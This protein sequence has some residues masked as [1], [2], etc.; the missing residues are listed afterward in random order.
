M[1]VKNAVFLAIILFSLCL[2]SCNDSGNTGNVDGDNDFSGSEDTTD[3]IVMKGGS[4]DGGNAKEVYINFNF[5]TTANSKI[6]WKEVMLNIN[7]IGL[8]E[9]SD[10]ENQS[11]ILSSDA[12]P[13]SVSVMDAINSHLLLLVPVNRDFCS[14]NFALPSNNI[15]F[16]AK[17]VTSDNTEIIIETDLG[18]FITIEPAT[19]FFKFSENKDYKWVASFDLDSFIGDGYFAKLQTGSDGKIVVSSTSNYF[20]YNHV[21]EN[22]KLSLV[23]IE[24]QNGNGERDNDAD[25][26]EPIV[27]RGEIQIVADGDQD[28][29]EDHISDGDYEFDIE[30]DTQELSEDI[31]DDSETESPENDS[32]EEDVFID[33]DNDG[34]DDTIDNCLGVKNTDQLD[35]DEDDV[36]D[37]CDNCIYTYNPNQEDHDDNDVGDACD[38]SPP[39]ELCRMIECFSIFDYCATMDMECIGSSG[40]TRGFCSSS[41]QNA[42]DC[43][44]PYSCIEGSC[45]CQDWT[46]PPAC[47]RVACS[48]PLDCLENNEVCNLLDG[49]C[50]RTCEN[51]AYCQSMY[52]ERWSC[53]FVIALASDAC[54]CN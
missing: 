51:D 19:G 1:Q 36:G 28:T 33:D 26:H 32:A 41:C 27:G 12:G 10:C 54:V 48:N 29:D 37:L 2:F 25:F 50:T 38:I 43:I 31:E 24:D 7:S 40:L 9:F 22:I 45:R 11:V 46:P 44:L 23:I 17:G 34:V 16:Q 47:E 30:D 13:L 4:E 5:E 8:S 20:A 14:L 21:V 35:T 6:T 52:G 3:Y 42:D 18:G 15:S 39:S 49:Y 53:E